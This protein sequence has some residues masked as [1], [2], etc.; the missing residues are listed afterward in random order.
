MDQNW[1][2]DKFKNVMILHVK[3]MTGCISNDILLEL[4]ICLALCDIFINKNIYIFIFLSMRE[5]A[6]ILLRDLQMTRRLGK[7]G[8]EQECKPF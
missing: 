1:L 8:K 6:K 7:S 2:I 5:K 4:G 3:L